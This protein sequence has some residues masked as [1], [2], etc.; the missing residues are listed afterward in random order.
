MNAIMLAGVDK[1]KV[2]GWKRFVMSTTSTAAQIEKETLDAEA[3]AEAT[4]ES[5]AKY[6]KQR[7]GA[8]L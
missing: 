1:A 7:T 2:D 4:G 3:R 5:H 8:I 6:G